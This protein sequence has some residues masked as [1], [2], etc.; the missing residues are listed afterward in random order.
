AIAG[1][2]TMAPGASVTYQCTT[3]ALSQDFTNVAVATG[4]PAAGPDVTASDSAR[5]DVIAPE[6]TIVKGPD[7]QVVLSGSTVT[8]SITVKNT[9]DAVLT[10]VHV[11]D[12]KTADCARTA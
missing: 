3:G 11:D 10:G 2:A 9:G 6:I 7:G 1:L 12:A 4:T 5:V 8:F